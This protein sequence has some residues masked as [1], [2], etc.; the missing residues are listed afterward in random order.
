MD[1]FAKRRER[2]KESIR[3]AAQQLFMDRGFRA[4]SIAEI[5]ALAGVSQVSIYNYF[6]SKEKLAIYVI[7]QYMAEQLQVFTDIIESPQPF[8]V[9]LEKAFFQSAKAYE[10][11]HMEFIDTFI[12]SDPKIAKLLVAY[13]EKL[14]PYMMKFIEQG[15]EEGYFNKDLSQE[16][17]LFYFNLF[18]S[19]AMQQLEKMPKGEKKRRV[20]NE[21]LSVFFYGVRGEG[22][23]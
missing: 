17:L 10:T 15:W 14:F 16:T 20:Y 22:E 1:G 19:Q 21:L 5:A 8:L 7:D 11:I 23:N 18:S 12:S 4:V 6:G 3:L 13:E 9:K 2:K